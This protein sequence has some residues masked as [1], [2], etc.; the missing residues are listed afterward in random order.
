MHYS[1]WLSF[2]TYTIITAVTPGPNNIL[3][4]N[5][6]GRAGLKQSKNILLGIYSGFTCIML[7]CGLFSATLS[8]L[9][10][11]IMLYLKYI[12]ATY[13]IWLAWHV[14]VS[15]PPDIS[16]Q[17]LEQSFWRG[18]WLQFVNVKII[19]YGITAFTGFILPYY[20]NPFSIGAFILLLSLIGNGATHLWAI[21]GAALSTFLGRH[22]RIANIS[23]SCLLLF[24][25]FNLFYE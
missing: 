10:P 13:I 8:V 7:I 9:L 5:A 14:A 17:S 11:G 6:T 1:I 15:T 2:F 16:G 18:F 12:G 25:A 21:A 20:Q 24:S 19:L 4:L 23:M 3:A 22:W